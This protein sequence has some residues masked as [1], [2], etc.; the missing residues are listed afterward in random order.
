MVA[1]ASPYEHLLLR[2]HP[3][4]SWSFPNSPDDDELD[5][6]PRV[7]FG[8]AMN[9]LKSLGAQ[10][11]VPHMYC[12][13]GMTT[14]R[15]LFKLLGIPLVGNGAEAMALSTNK[16]H[17]RAIMASA[18]VPVAEGQLLRRGDIPTLEPPFILKPNRE[19]NSQGITLFRGGSDDELREA[20]EHAFTFDNEVICEAFVPLGHEVRVTVLEDDAGEPNILLPVCE[21][22]MDPAS[23]NRPRQASYR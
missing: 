7:S 22:V 16:W 14:C 17:T 23:E 8:D 15:G 1:V 13:Q 19:D 5:R 12:L 21:Y 18:G 6:A 9:Q 20:L 10:V 4:G 2:S 3:D 11:V